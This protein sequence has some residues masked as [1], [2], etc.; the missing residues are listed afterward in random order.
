MKLTLLT[1]RSF[2]VF[3]RYCTLHWQIY[4]CLLLE[5]PQNC[6]H[7]SEHSKLHGQTLWYRPPHALY[8]TMLVALY[9]QTW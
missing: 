6:N 5:E 1:M 2:R 3:E 9:N 8:M 7:V 4:L